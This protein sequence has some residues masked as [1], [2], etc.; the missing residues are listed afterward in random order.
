M[1]AETKITVKFIK[2]VEDEIEVQAV[3]LEEAREQVRKIPGVVLV[4][5]AGY[6]GEPGFTKL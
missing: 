6:S 5:E 4:L 2:T 1:G 3:T